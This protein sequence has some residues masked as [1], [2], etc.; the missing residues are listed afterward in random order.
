MTTVRNIKAIDT[1][2]LGT[3]APSGQGFATR[4]LILEALLDVQGQ[5]ELPRG[6][7]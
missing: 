6:S 2:Y 4:D 7:R 1:P 3:L 5:M